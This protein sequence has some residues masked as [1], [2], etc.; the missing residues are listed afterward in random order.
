MQMKQYL[1]AADAIR[2]ADKTLTFPNETGTILTTASSIANSNLANSAVTIGSTSV[3]L[4]ATAS[5]NFR[6]GLKL[7]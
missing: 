4:G 7:L 2:T 6:I 3:S 5:G 1:T